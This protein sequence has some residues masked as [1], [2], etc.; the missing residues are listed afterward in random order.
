MRY[1][2]DTDD[3][4]RAYPFQ[5]LLC[6]LLDVLGLFTITG[7]PNGRTVLISSPV[8]PAFALGDSFVLVV[9]IEFRIKVA[10]FTA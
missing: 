10:N 4:H 2:N 8:R 1:P 9:T 3:G 6:S 7:C 5:P